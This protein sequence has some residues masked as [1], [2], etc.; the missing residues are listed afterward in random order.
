M[1]NKFVS[2]EFMKYS[3]RI[4]SN[5]VR[6][7]STEFRERMFLAGFL[8]LLKTSNSNHKIYLGGDVYRGK[9]SHFSNK[10]K[11]CLRVLVVFF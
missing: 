4:C 7:K 9:I 8:Y 2:C 10:S 6:H 5:W 1:A 11:V 3:P